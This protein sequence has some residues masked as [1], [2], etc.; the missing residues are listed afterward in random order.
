MCV[1]GL[2]LLIQEES[3]VKPDQ[4]RLVMDNNELDEGKLD[5]PSYIKDIPGITNGSTIHLVL[6]NN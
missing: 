3:G 1:Q 5:A 6:K 4:M 2:K